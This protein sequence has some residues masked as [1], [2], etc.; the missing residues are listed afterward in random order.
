MTRFTLGISHVSRDGRINVMSRR[1]VSCYA[2]M[3]LVLVLFS[4]CAKTRPMTERLDN[5]FS[6][7]G[8]VTNFQYYISRNIV[9]RITET[10]DVVGKVAGKG[11]IK[12]TKHRNVIQITSTTMGALLKTEV[13]DLGYK[14]YYVAF[15]SDNDNCLRFSQLKPGLDE[16]IYLEYD[17]NAK[18]TVKY[19][20]AYYTVELEG[21]ESVKLNKVRAKFDNAFS[22]FKGKLKGI[23]SD[24]SDSPY[25]LVKT[26]I[27]VEEKENYRKASGRKVIVK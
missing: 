4:S 17:D 2:C 12:V 15:E 9:L 14:V 7:V 13:D 10:P 20:D 18:H 11:E 1:V 23:K 19:G 22:K 6:S 5:T 24:E 16:R 25:L 8:K 3:V 27:K 26:K 21:V